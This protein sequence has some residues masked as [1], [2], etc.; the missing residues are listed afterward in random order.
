MW[1]MHERK[2]GGEANQDGAECVA[3]DVLSRRVA[4]KPTAQCR[5][6]NRKKPVGRKP[7]GY[8]HRTEEGEL[9]KHPMIVRVDELRK[10]DGAE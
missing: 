1:C 2:I 5:S 4:G 7:N 8:E 9:L 3:L 10:Q 6:A